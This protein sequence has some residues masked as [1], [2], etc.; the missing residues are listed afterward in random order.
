MINDGISSGAAPYETTWRCGSY[1]FR[2]AGD[3]SRRDARI[4]DVIQG[5]TR[6]WSQIVCFIITHDDVGD[7][8][9]GRSMITSNH[10]PST[11]TTIRSSCSRRTSSSR[12]GDRRGARWMDAGI[13]K[14]RLGTTWRNVSG[15]KRRIRSNGRYIWMS[16]SANSIFWDP[17]IKFGRRSCDGTR[18][19]SVRTAAFQTQTAGQLPCTVPPAYG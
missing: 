15:T 5:P 8:G 4:R 16:K 13:I 1:I 18:T 17:I 3:A 12:W 10:G 7:A 2:V 9:R 6:R 14:P 19:T 11:R